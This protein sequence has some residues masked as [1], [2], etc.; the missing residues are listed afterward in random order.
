[1]SDFL[2]SELGMLTIYAVPFV[3]A[4]VMPGWR[5]LAIMSVLLGGLIGWA[6]IRVESSPPK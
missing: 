3:L 1:M 4:A 2:F 5:S 6:M